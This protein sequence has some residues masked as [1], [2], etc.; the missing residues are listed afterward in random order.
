MT[1]SETKTCNSCHKPNNN[2][3]S[4]F[5]HGNCLPC[6][7]RAHQRAPQDKLP[8]K[9]QSVLVLTLT[10]TALA[11]IAISIRTI[12]YQHIVFPYFQRG[13]TLRHEFTNLEVAIPIMILL[14]LASGLLATAIVTA[15]YNKRF[16]SK[17]YKKK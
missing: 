6:R 17:P 16:N 10:T 11:L 7:Q 13:R 14:L 3:P 5:K 1:K 4:D 12:Y 8:I 15:N 2:K 9:L